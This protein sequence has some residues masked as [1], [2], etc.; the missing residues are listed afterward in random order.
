MS[1]GINHLSHT[2][3]PV[4]CF[5]MNCKGFEPS[6]AGLDDRC[7]TTE[8]TVFP[9]CAGPIAPYLV[10]YRIQHTSMSFGLRPT[11]RYFTSPGFVSPSTLVLHGALCREASNYSCYPL[12]VIARLVGMN[13]A[14]RQTFRC[15]LVRIPL[16]FRTV[17]PDLPTSATKWL[18]THYATVS[19]R[20]QSR[21]A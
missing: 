11:Q 2:T 17:F 8:L 3:G 12:T 9:R 16:C 1:Y 15:T 4:F 5:F 20:S 19:R 7:S 18:M 14:G 10:R 6:T 21:L 13:T